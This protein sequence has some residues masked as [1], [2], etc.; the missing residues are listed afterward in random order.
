MSKRSASLSH[1]ELA[2]RQ[3]AKIKEE[4]LFSRIHPE[5][6]L[7]DMKGLPRKRFLTEIVLLTK[8]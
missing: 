3:N 4:M 7:A 6:V 8:K 1:R 2:H 5:L